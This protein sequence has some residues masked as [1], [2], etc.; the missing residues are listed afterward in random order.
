[1]GEKS[2][3]STHQ[4]F[5]LLKFPSVTNTFVLTKYNGGECDLF[6]DAQSIKELHSEDRN[7]NISVL[8]NLDNP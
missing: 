8:V 6:F 4:C 1:M 7:T 2:S 3:F 5:Y